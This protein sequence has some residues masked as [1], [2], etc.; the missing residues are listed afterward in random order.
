MTWQKV[1][2]QARRT[3]EAAIGA[4]YVLLLALAM[5]GCAAN[6]RGGV[7]QGGTY[8][9]RSQQPPDAA[10]RCFARN[11][12]EHSSAL[13]AEVTRREDAAEVIVRVKNGLTYATATFRASGRGSTGSITLMVV[14]SGGQSDLLQSLTEGC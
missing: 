14:S 2:A 4:G 6:P 3:F 1:L 7:S 9:Y 12:E 13:V 10:A 8:S 11:A 5:A